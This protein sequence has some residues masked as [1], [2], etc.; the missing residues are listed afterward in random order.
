MKEKLKVIGKIRIIVLDARTGKVKEITEKENVLTNLLFNLYRDA[1]AGDLT[2][3][4]DLKIWG[5]ALGDN[6]TAP[7]VT[8]TLLGNE[9][10]R[11]ALTDTDK[12]ETGE[13]FTEVYIDPADGNG[14][15]E[16]IGWFAGTSASATKDT[17]TLIARVLYSREK[18]AEEAWIIERIDAIEEAA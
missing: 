8:D 16:E 6:N 7:T 3:K 4:D 9:T 15:I 18:T 13:Y 12:P 5:L 17:G 11:Q 1:L 14:T 10:Y 2:H